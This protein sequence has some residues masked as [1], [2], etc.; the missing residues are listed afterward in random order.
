MYTLLLL[1]T[2]SGKFIDIE[3]RVV[4][5]Q[6]ALRV[7]L[8]NKLQTRS[9]LRF[10]E[11]VGNYGRLGACLVERESYISSVLLLSR[12][13]SHIL[14]SLLIFHSLAHRLTRD[15]FDAD[16]EREDREKM[17]EARLRR[18]RTFV[19][20]IQTS[21]AARKCVPLCIIHLIHEF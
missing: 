1:D 15:E 12:A 18:T 3:Y 4:W 14:Q 7:S 10:T 2:F 20:T 19:D 8:A 5:R 9:N 16:Y 11:R 6:R 17:S 13:F 21:T